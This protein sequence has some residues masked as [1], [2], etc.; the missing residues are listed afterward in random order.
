MSGD[1][2]EKINRRAILKGTWF[3][4]AAFF[5]MMLHVLQWLFCYSTF[6]PVTLPLSLFLFGGLPLAWWTARKCRGWLTR[7]FDG[8]DN[9]I[10]HIGVMLLMVSWI[11]PAL[12]LSTNFLLADKAVSKE[13]L[14]VASRGD[15]YK[16]GRTYYWVKI[17]KH[18]VS[19]KF[20]LPDSMALNTVDSVEIAVRKGYLGFEC[21]EYP[22][23][24]QRYGH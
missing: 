10:M 6:I 21:F 18:N 5:F 24:I 3:L 13:T 20:T 4:I 1:K 12:V 14:P 11:P 16:K 23:F 8:I 7:V 17:E 9:N 22:R 15:R 2:K 19:R